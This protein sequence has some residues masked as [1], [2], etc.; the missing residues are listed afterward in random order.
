MAT[1]QR[2]RTEEA[3][4]IRR[5]AILD[6]AARMLD[7]MP[8]SRITLN[9]LSRRSHLAK[10][11]IL[12]YFESREAIL[13]ELLDRAW[14]QWTAD[15]GEHLASEPSLARSAR[16]RGAEF[17]SVLGAAFAANT[18]LCDLLSAQAGVLEHNVSADVAS[19]YKN[20]ALANVA[21]LVDLTRTRL[22]ELGSGAD[23]LCGQV[24]MATGAV[25]THSRPSAGML[26]A[27]EA[28]PELARYRMDFRPALESMIATLVAGAL[29]LADGHRPPR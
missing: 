25:W 15:L 23:R 10:S 29:A 18:T 19:R 5:E 11:A 7:E 24:V 22:P 13:L 12:K 1:F 6:T 20:A 26:A 8:T 21:A 3:Q 16:D 2:A 14:K 4:E 28:D 9:E 27:Y 17:A